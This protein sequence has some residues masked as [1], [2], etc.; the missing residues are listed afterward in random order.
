MEQINS[1]TFV[2]WA[3]ISRSPV[4][5]CIAKAMAEEKGLL[6]VKCASAGLIE[7]PFMDLSYEMRS[8]LERLGYQPPKHHIPTRATAELLGNSDLVLCFERDQV[9]QVRALTGIGEAGNV[10]TLP[11]YVGFP[12]QEIPD[13]HSLIRATWLSGVINSLPPLLKPPFY[14]IT[15]YVHPTDE[16]AVLK[17]HIR[18][19]RQIE[20]Y[21]EEAI[22][23]IA[24]THSQ[25]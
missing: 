16:Q 18:L 13:P 10:Y 25:G 24:K 23:K 19:A 2:C 11:E 22:E 7:P 14:G 6:G 4:A 17:V 21:V 1:V 8:A 9:R 15:G 5:E 20:E 12:E 3:N